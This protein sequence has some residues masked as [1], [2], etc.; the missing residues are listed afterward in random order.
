LAVIRWRGWLEL[1]FREDYLVSLFIAAGFVW[2]K[3][4]CALTYYGEVNAFRPRPNRIDLASYGI[5]AAERLGWH[6][7]ERDGRWTTGPAQLP[8]D[9]GGQHTHIQVVVANHLGQ[10][11]D[12]TLACGESHMSLRLASPDHLLVTIPCPPGTPMLD[13]IAEPVQTASSV[14]GRLLGIFVRSFEYLILDAE[15]AADIMTIVQL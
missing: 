9:T 5:P 7:P 10:A 1:G 13:I 14:D 2:T 11:I 12:C 6:L 15:A 4:P 8:L 3:F